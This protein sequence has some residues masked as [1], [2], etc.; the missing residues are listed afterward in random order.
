[1]SSR[2]E[3]LGYE[4]SINSAVVIGASSA[5]AETLDAMPGPEELVSEE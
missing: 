4:G 2:T 1:M 5:T 3:E